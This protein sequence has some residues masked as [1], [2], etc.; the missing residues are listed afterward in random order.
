MWQ[1][2]S[3][4]SKVRTTAKRATSSWRTCSKNSAATAILRG[5]GRSVYKESWHTSQGTQVHAKQSGDKAGYSSGAG[6]AVLDKPLCAQLGTCI[7][8][9]MEH[10]VLGWVLLLGT[11]AGAWAGGRKLSAMKEVAMDMAPS[12]FDDQYQGCIDLM[13]AELEELNR[14]EFTTDIYAEGWRRA[15]AEW[16][17]RWGRAARPPALRR[18]QATAM[19]AYMLEGNLYHQFNNATLTAGRSR[20]HYLRSYPFKAL[21]FLLSRA[22]QTLRESQTQRCFQVYHGIRNVRYTAQQGKVVRFGRFTS[23][24]LQQIIPGIYAPDTIFSVETCYGAPVQNFTTIPEQGKVLIPPFEQFR[25][26]NSTYIA[27]RSFIQL[28]SH[29]KSSTYNCEFVK[30]KGCSAP[31][32]GTWVDRGY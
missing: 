25:V 30:G 3:H 6:G 26:I 16:Q 20:Q 31:R 27:G 21:H 2:N 29:G 23:T 22:L 24:S 14:T 13:A 15:A 5:Y 18:D 32:W 7:L 19:M 17:S 1:R 8:L 9:H 4:A 10:I 12:S 11:W 28:R